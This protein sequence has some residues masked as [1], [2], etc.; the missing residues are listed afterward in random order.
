MEFFEAVK[1]CFRKYAD[2]TG[3]ATRSEYWWFQLFLILAAMVAGVIA[4]AV[5]QPL[6]LIYHLAV[7]LPNLAVGVRRLHDIDRSGWMLLIALV[8]LIGIILLIVW[9]CQKSDAVANRFGP[10]ELPR[11]ALTAET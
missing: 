6:A 2:F 11:H 5:W 7:I 10:P 1:T 4:G 3:R 9:F 8:P